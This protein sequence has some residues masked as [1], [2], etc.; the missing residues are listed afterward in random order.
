MAGANSTRWSYAT[1]DITQQ[2]A[3]VLALNVF[4]QIT[5][6]GN[7]ICIRGTH[8]LGGATPTN[9]AVLIVTGKDGRRGISTALITRTAVGGGR[10]HW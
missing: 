2:A 1:F 6:I 9:D 10:H 4:A 5:Q 8:G 7:E 3:P